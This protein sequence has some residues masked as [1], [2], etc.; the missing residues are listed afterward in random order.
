MKDYG[1]VGKEGKIHSASRPYPRVPQ[2]GVNSK[3]NWGGN[4]RGQ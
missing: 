1:S 3:K 4:S 2:N